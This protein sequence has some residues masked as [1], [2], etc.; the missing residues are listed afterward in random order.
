MNNKKLCEHRGCPLLAADTFCGF[1]TRLHA[2]D[3]PGASEMA[4]PLLEQDERIVH[5]S[6]SANYAQEWDGGSKLKS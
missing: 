4:K 5:A 6:L 2:G 1:H 3:K